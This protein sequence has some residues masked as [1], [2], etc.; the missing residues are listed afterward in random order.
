M[1]NFNIKQILFA[2]SVALILSACGGGSSNTTVI[3]VVPVPSCGTGADLGKANAVSVLGKTI[4]KGNDGAEVRIWHSAT[5]KVACMIV[6]EA[7]IN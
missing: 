1:K 4:V 5:D 3:T 7:I 6:G 2:S